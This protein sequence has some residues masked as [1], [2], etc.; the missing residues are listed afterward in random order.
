MD[1]LEHDANYIISI[2][3]TTKPEFSGVVKKLES[4]DAAVISEWIAESLDLIYND[5]SIETLGA[6]DEACMVIAVIAQ[7]LVRYMCKK[8]MQLMTPEAVIL[9]RK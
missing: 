8:L 4:C 7:W 2:L 6:S 9:K 5:E 3:A 1:E